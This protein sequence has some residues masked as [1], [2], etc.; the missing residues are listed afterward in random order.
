MGHAITEHESLRAL[1]GLFRTINDGSRISFQT[2]SEAIAGEHLDSFDLIDLAT[3][4]HDH[5]IELNW[6]TWSSHLVEQMGWSDSSVTDSGGPENM[7]EQYFRDV[8]NHKILSADEEVELFRELEHG[9][10]W[11]RRLGYTTGHVFEQFRNHVDQIESGEKTVKSILGVSRSTS[12]NEQEERQHLDQLID[13]RTQL[14]HLHENIKES[15]DSTNSAVFVPRNLFGQMIRIYE[16]LNLDDDLIIEWTEEIQNKS[17]ATSETLSDAQRTIF[18]KALSLADAHW[19]IYREKIASSN[20]KLVLSIAR[21]YKGKELDFLD[22]IQ[23]GNLG[24]LRAIKKFDHE[25]GYKFST[26]ATWWIRQ[27]MQRAIQDKGSTIRIPVHSRE[28]MDDVFRAREELKKSLHREP[29]VEELAKKLNWKEKQVRK[30]MNIQEETV[31]LESP[32]KNGESETE[33]KHVVEDDSSESPFAELSQDDLRAA[34]EDA[35]DDL[36]WRETQVI[37]MRYGLDSEEKHTLEQIGNS[38]NI[39]RER[40]RQIEINALE[41]LKHPTRSEKLVDFIDKQSQKS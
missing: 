15:A 40:A 5:G 2:L 26:Y 36:N 23:E 4:L 10:N 21:K 35:L 20:L 18:H 32:L 37:R 12:L 17:W 8:V 24:L 41:M 3:W 33:L 1:E 29:T 6:E 28:K 31:S 14:Q 30:I 7:I 11:F 34:L 19:R 38:F 9:K 13:A 22:L 16:K 25:K 39:T 27:S